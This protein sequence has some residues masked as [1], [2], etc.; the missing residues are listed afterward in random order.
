MRCDN[1]RKWQL[2]SD[3]LEWFKDDAFEIQRLLEQSDNNQD[4]QIK[5]KITD[6]INS[7]VEKSKTEETETKEISNP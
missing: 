2:M 6:I 4:P 5:A 7:A 3:H 1:C